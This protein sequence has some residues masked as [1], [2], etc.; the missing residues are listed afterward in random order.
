MRLRAA[1]RSTC[2]A[3]RAKNPARNSPF[4]RCMIAEQDFRLSIANICSIRFTPDAKRGAD[5][6][7]AFQNAG[8]SSNNTADES[9]ASRHP[10]PEHCFESFGQRNNRPVRTD[11]W[12]TQ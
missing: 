1:L 10:K 3:V 2:L 8:A 9:N 12:R 4:L 11:E 7:L 5:L 6:D